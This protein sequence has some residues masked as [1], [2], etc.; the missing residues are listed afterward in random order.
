MPQIGCKIKQLFADMQK[1]LYFCGLI[2]SFVATMALLHIETST[3]VCSVA[4]T[5]GNEI[6][7]HRLSEP[8]VQ[9]AAVLP[10]YIQEAVSAIRSKGYNVEG[11]AVSEGPGSYTGLRIGV[12]TAKG[13]AYGFQ[14]KLIAIPTL[15]LL[16]LEAAQAVTAETDTLLCPMIDARRMEV[17]TAL[18]DR[19]LNTIEEVRPQVVEADTF[20]YVLDKHKVCF[21]GDGADKC[22]AVISHP[23]AIFIDN[24]RPDA[25]YMMPLAIK[26][27]AEG[28][29][30]DTAYFEPFY[31]KEF[32]AAASHVKGLQ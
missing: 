8:S 21:F 32:V 10:L 6:V 4:L 11:V 23:N 3:S 2:L 14:T 17:Y 26:Q 20:N 30:E 31:L 19:E 16:A 25:M 24:I 15:T 27:L 18:Y 7:F 5:E 13:L 1:K 28:K 12:S 29:T 9:H 22:K